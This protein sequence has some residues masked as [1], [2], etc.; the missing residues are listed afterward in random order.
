I[1]I[2]FGAIGPFI[3]GFFVR[4]DILK[5]QL[6]ATKATCQAITHLIKITLFGFIGINV[7]SYWKLLAVLCGAVIIG[8]IIGKRILG[9]MSDEVFK[10]IFKVLLTLLAL[11]IVVKQVMTLTGL[12]LL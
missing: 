12:T 8:T 11:W 2:F 3:A 1:G 5:E 9:K 4:K 7:F 6:V 10:K